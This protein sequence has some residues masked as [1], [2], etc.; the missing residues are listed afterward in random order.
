MDDDTQ[1][2]DGLLA[3][4]SRVLGTLRGTVENRVE[5]FLLEA[6]EDRLK[7]VEAVCLAVVAAGLAVMAM[8][9]VTFTIV[10]VFWDSYR[11][12]ALVTLTL[13][14]GTGAGLA[15]LKLRSRLKNWQSFPATFE[16]LEKDRACF[17]SRK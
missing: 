10:V 1:G 11:L 6:R 8:I 16:Q 13:L 14:Y 2:G 5:L 9:L 12:T 7:L 17:K 3:T 15:L 4:V